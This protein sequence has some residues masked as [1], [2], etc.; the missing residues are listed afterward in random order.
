M[1]QLFA[2]N[3]PH[4]LSSDGDPQWEVAWP[5][6]NVPSLVELLVVRHILHHK[7]KCGTLQTRINIIPLHVALRLGPHS[8]PQSL[9]CFSSLLRMDGD[10]CQQVKR[11]TFGEPCF[12]DRPQPMLVR[13]HLQVMCL[14]NRSNVL[15]SAFRHDL[16][17]AKVLLGRILHDERLQRIAACDALRASFAHLQEG[18][19]H[20]TQQDSRVRRQLHDRGDAADN[21]HLKRM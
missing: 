21:P 20:R 12:I 7:G 5:A 11:F 3:G 10:R 17:S 19:V 16:A 18:R 4:P 14:K 15:R 8:T 9:P 2:E 1:H 13:D 6:P